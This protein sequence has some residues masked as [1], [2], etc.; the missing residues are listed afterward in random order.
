MARYHLDTNIGNTS[1]FKR[2]EISAFSPDELL[3]T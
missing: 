1:E 3:Q 2:F